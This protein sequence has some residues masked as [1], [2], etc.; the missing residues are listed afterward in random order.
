MFGVDNRAIDSAEENRVTAPS[1]DRCQQR[2]RGVA[3]VFVVVDSG[4][5]LMAGWRS[6]PP[7]HAGK[8]QLQNATDAAASPPR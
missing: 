1:I 2:R 8:A 7:P 6:M 5:L 3:M 4:L